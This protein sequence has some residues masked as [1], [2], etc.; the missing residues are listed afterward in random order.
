[1]RHGQLVAFA[2]I[3]KCSTTI[4]RTKP[5]E[6]STARLA[7]E[8]RGRF[9]RRLIEPFFTRIQIRVGRHIE[10]TVLRSKCCPLPF[11]IRPCNAV[12]SSVSKGLDFHLRKASL[13]CLFEDARHPR[14]GIE[15]LALYN[16]EHRKFAVLVAE[17]LI[18]RFCVDD[19]MENLPELDVVFP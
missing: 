3:E 8:H 4:S 19:V 11:S 17:W 15:R 18:G 9:K 16:T 13:R 1:M 7:T 2:T 5:I 6:R 10:S 12:R 14:V